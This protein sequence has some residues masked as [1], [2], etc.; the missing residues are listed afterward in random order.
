MDIWH[1][2]ST[3]ISRCLHEKIN[4]LL[5]SDWHNMKLF[6][7]LKMLKRIL[8]SVKR[9]GTSSALLTHARRKSSSRAPKMPPGYTPS[10]RI[11]LTQPLTLLKSNEY[12]GFS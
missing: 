7:G 5:V 3:E 1:E 4:D 8:N 11:R 9:E 2:C 10:I 12:A 6:H